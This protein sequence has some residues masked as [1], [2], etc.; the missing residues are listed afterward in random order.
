MALFKVQG[1]W[2]KYV[3]APNEPRGGRRSEG[4]VASNGA[5]FEGVDEILLLFMS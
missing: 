5:C 4:T 1:E 2:E 3:I